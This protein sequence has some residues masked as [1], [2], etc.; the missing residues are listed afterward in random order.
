[1]VLDL[2]RRLRLLQAEFL[3][4]R[5]DS[6]LRFEVIF[7]FPLRVVEDVAAVLVRERGMPFWRRLHGCVLRHG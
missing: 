5:G 2:V 6:G 1:M 4:L 7:G 3:E